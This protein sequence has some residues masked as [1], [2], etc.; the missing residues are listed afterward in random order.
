MAENPFLREQSLD[1]SDLIKY[2]EVVESAASLRPLEKI[3]VANFIMLIRPKVIFE[4]GVYKGV[5]TEFIYDFLQANGFTETRIIGFDLPEM[6]DGIRENNPKLRQLE[7]EGRIE[8]VP[9]SM[10]ES[11]SNWLDAH[12]NMQC[13]LALVDAMH[14]FENVTSELSL[15][16]PRLSQQGIILCHDY[17]PVGEHEGLCYAIDYFAM[18]TRGTHVMTL[19]SSTQADQF[20]YEGE[21]MAM[22]HSVLVGVRRRPYKFKWRTL[23]R[24]LR[25]EFIWK[26]R[27]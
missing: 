4:L 17:A 10:P 6:I 8:F 25:R 11:L 22:Y 7:E 15:L 24:Y 5:T 21:Q 23:L 26:R 20:L 13:E 1:F 2:P 16:W 12:P 18:R 9:G 27:R 3:F 14:S 19:G